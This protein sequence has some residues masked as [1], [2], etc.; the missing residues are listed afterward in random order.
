MN[1]NIDIPRDSTYLT[2]ECQTCL[3]QLHARITPLIF[4]YKG[5]RESLLKEIMPLVKFIYERSETINELA[6]K[7]KLWDGDIIFRSLVE[8]FLKLMYIITGSYPDI[9]KR[10]D[11]YC[12]D[13]DDFDKI[14]HSEHAKKLVENDYN[15]PSFKAQILT[16]EEVDAIKSK[17]SWSNRQKLANAWS[18]NEIVKYLSSNYKGPVLF[19]WQGVLYKYRMGSHIAHADALGTGVIAGTKNREEYWL[20]LSAFAHKC[21]LLIDVLRF[22]IFTNKLLFEFLG[23]E[24]DYS[25]GPLYLYFINNLVPVH[26]KYLNELYKNPVYNE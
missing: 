20:L 6:V 11:Q 8:A 15:N 10:L 5:P 3:E 13:L 24:T 16:D 23:Y 17:P 9:I 19:S 26:Q 14:K 12:N 21:Q 1:Q 4:T 18:V 2:H 7:D 25:I 22:N